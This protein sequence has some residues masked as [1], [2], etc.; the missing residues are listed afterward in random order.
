M[1]NRPISDEHLS[2]KPKSNEYQ[3]RVY[4]IQGNEVKLYIQIG[5]Y[6]FNK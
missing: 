6:V 4:N 1:F 3:S 5:M 2:N